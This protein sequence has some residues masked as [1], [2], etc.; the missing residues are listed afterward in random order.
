MEAL[1]GKRAR[2]PLTNPLTLRV[3]FDSHPLRGIDVVYEEVWL[4]DEN[5]IRYQRNLQIWRTDQD[6]EKTLEEIIA[7]REEINSPS[8]PWSGK[9]SWR[10]SI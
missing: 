7:Q 10:D 2:V 6:N 9:I 5:T 4:I 1:K 8:K 3:S